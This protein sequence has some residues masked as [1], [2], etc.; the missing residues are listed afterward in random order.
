MKITFLGATREVTGSC[1]LVEAGRTR[2]LVD[3]GMFQG[4]A[5]TEAKNFEDFAFDPKTIDAVIVTHAHL[6]HVGR[7]PKL[8]KEGFH[9]RIYLTPPTA[10]IAHV[11]LT[12][13][14]HIMKDE[15]RKHARP[16]LYEGDDVEH[17][18]Q[19]FI[20]VDYSRTVKLPNV[21]LR[22]R[23]AGHIFGSAF[24]ELTES[25][26]GRTVFSGDLG[27]R[28]VPILRP[29]A[30]MASADAVIVESTYGNRLHEDESTRET[31]LK[32]A[33]TDT[34]KNNGVLVIPAFAIERTQQVLYEMNE[35]VERGEIPQVDIFLDSPM[36][37][38]VT[39]II[40]EYPRYYDSDAMKHISKGDNMFHFPGLRLCM[41]KDD[42]KIIN[43]VPPPKVIIAGAGMMNGGRIQHHLVRYL[44]RKSTTVLII[45]YQ[46]EGT[47][48]RQLYSGKKVVNVLNERVD[49]KA[50]IVSIGAYS[51]H[52]D[53]L[54]LVEWISSAPKK[55]TNVYCTHGE[56]A[57]A[58]ALASRINE[59]LGVSADVP[60]LGETVEV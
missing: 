30:Q 21:S 10:K 40:S 27:N 46:A 43:D 38:R 50:N 17:A 48:G 58:G 23:D 25:G 31:R 35:M 2:L 3:C 53:Q 55:P 11:V 14:E 51:A 19:R 7:L 5:F 32:K 22:F 36:A 45:G 15:W 28:D 56:E 49:V 52:A 13:A 9:G 59:E 20:P 39:D 33:I 18:A 24:V 34:V 37:I 47:L 42:S 12:D 8:V 6:D 41:T 60:R 54:K 44:G 26:G 57:A 4:S 16:M 1:Y 29:T